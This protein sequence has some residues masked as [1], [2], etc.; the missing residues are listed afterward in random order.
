MFI[1]TL[2]LNYNLI[3]IT[4]SSYH[5]LVIFKDNFYPQ[6][7]NTYRRMTNGQFNCWQQLLKVVKIMKPRFQPAVCA[8]TA[9][10]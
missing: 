10:I 5:K 6:N 7:G 2:K 9:K 4:K 1:I 3:I 8:F